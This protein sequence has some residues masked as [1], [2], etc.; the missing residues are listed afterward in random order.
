MTKEREETYSNCYVTSYVITSSNYMTD[1][2][3]Y[4]IAH[5]SHLSSLYTH[6]MQVKA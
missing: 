4:A 2:C 1:T 3:R 5:P 6:A